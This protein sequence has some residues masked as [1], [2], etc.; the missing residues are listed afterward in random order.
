M[1]P[2]LRIPL[3]R[4][5]P[6]VAP[7]PAPAVR[8]A[9]GRTRNETILVVEDDDGVRQQSVESLRELGYRVIEARDGASALE[10]LAE[11]GDVA[12]L[13]TDVV[14]PG[15]RSGAQLASQVRAPKPTCGCC[16]RPAMPAMPSS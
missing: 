5:L 13:F 16:S 11:H 8:S 9:P 14:L 12:L 15:G 3:P 7:A 1:A 4:L 10:G 2:T 6:R